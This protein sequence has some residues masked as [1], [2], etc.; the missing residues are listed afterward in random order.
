MP[1]RSSGRY[2][3]FRAKRRNEASYQVRVF[4]ASSIDLNLVRAF[5]LDACKFGFLSAIRKWTV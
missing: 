2:S 4:L 1:G 3:F 5:L